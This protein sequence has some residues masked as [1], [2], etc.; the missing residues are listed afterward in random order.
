[1]FFSKTENDRSG[2]CQSREFIQHAL[3]K[4]LSPEAHFLQLLKVKLGEKREMNMKILAVVTCLILAVM[5]IAPTVTPVHASPAV[6][7]TIQFKYYSSADS[8]F[9]ALLEP[10]SLGGV[11]SMQWPLTYSQYQNVL[12]NPAITVEPVVEAGE[13]ELAFNNNVTDG[14]PAT[15]AAGIP[16]DPMNF[17]DFRNAMNLLVNKVA[18]ITGPTLQGFATESDTQ[19]PTP[20]M[21]A[22]VNTA[23][24]GPNYPWVFSVPKALTI[25]WNGGWFNHT[26]YTTAQNLINVQAAGGLTGNLTGSGNGPYT[27]NGNTVVYPLNDPNG[28]A[29]WQDGV[30]DPNGAADAAF[31]GQSIKTLWGGVR[32]NDARIDLG[33]NFCA[34]LKAIGCPYVENLFPTLTALRPYVLAKQ[35]YDFATLGYSFGAPPNWWYSELTPAGIYANGP[36]P[37]LVNDWNTTNYAYASF[38]DSNPATFTADEETVQYNLVM[39]SFFVPVYCPATYCA[40]VQGLLG[41]IDVLGQGTQSNGGMAENWIT[42]DTRA[43][44]PLSTTVYTL[45]LY[46]PPDMI[47]PIFQDTVFDFQVSDEIFTYPIGGN[48]YTIA[49]GSAITGAPGASDVPWMA[50]AW[51]TEL[52]NDPYNPA[53]PQWTNVTLW[54]RNDITWQDSAPFT[55]LDLNYTIYINSFYGDAYDNSAMIFAANVSAPGTPDAPYEAPVGS[56]NY[57]APYFKQDVTPL[58]PTGNYTCSILVSTPSW[59]NLYLPL[60]QTVPYHIYKYIQPSNITFAEEGASTDGLHGLWPGQGA[61]VVQPNPIGLTLASLADPTSTLVGTGPFSY[62]AGSMGSPPASSFAPGGGI[63]LD[64]YPHFFMTVAPSAISFQYKWLNTSPSQQPS[65][66]YYKIGLPDL[67]LM[68]NAYGTTGTP[69]STVSVS[70]N[71]GAP[72]TWNPA[73]DLTTP[74]GV[75]GLSD[76]ISLALHYGWYYGN[77]SYNAPYPA[78]EIANGGP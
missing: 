72:H 18:V 1:M 76:L 57:A 61:T 23:V 51:K 30:I 19:V 33:N 34:E 17:T 38:T 66:G 43:N 24:S 52:V 58:D 15:M 6:M 12:N 65:G 60:Y 20:L 68:A 11:D 71:S 31:A 37:Y 16:R 28:Q 27:G 55:D 7:N 41:Q 25:L 63:T 53:N 39:E 78:S 62:R 29:Y 46:N 64:A 70:S 75:V 48:P 32:S 47:N 50:Y 35:Q 22:Y 74:A 44:A 56:P 77:Y 21:Q 69:P 73:A 42:L 36:N 59:L 9:T 10:D 26:I 45:G 14:V 67:V 8:L 2:L 13:F 3:A 40:Y 49:V 54:L 4:V 5:M